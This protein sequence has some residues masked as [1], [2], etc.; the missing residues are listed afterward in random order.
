MI[1]SVC[2][3]RTPTS[4]LTLLNQRLPGIS[5]QAKPPILV[6]DS[7]FL[8]YVALCHLSLLPVASIRE[9]QSPSPFLSPLLTP[10]LSLYC[11]NH[12]NHPLR[13]VCLV[14]RGF[15]L[16]YLIFLYRPLLTLI[17]SHMPHALDAYHT[18]SSHLLYV[19]GDGISLASWIREEFGNRNQMTT[20]WK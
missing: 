11:S 13:Q 20:K 12:L 15:V 4:L 7:T 2:L 8:K 14:S 16:W 18:G 1:E 3:A 6:Q 19:I 10:S 9:H 17:I 5:S